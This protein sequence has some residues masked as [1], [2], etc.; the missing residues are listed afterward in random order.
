MSDA[1]PVFNDHES[2]RDYLLDQVAGDPKLREHVKVMDE[3]GEDLDASYF[4]IEAGGRFFVITVKAIGDDD[5]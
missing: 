4:E 3:T 5:D 1:T 2:I